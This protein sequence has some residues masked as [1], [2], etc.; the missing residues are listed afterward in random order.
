[1]LCELGEVLY[2]K[3]QQRAKQSNQKRNKYQFEIM[4]GDNFCT[5][6]K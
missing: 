6:H 1:M 2:G 4:L 3:R 5:I